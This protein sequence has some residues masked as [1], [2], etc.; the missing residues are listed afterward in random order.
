MR[1][2]LTKWR[3]WHFWPSAC[4]MGS[5]RLRIEPVRPGVDRGGIGSPRGC[6]SNPA[7]PD[8]GPMFSPDLLDHAGLQTT[9]DQKLPLKKGEKFVAVTLL[10]DRLYLR[11]DRNYLW[12][13][14]RVRATWSSAAP[15]RRPAFRC[16]A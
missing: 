11:S 9:W 12:S 8:S 15:S 6:R 5:L 16:W 7:P 14:D 10:G 13:L 2:V 1:R 3:R 4:G